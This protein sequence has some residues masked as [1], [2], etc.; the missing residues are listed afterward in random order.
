MESLKAK[1]EKS[2]REVGGRSV[3]CRAA[4]DGI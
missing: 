3:G 1:E 4:R 2:G